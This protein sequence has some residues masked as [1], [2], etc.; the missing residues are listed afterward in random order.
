MSPPSL[1]GAAL[2]PALGG[3]QGRHWLGYIQ[4]N[5]AAFKTIDPVND[6]RLL[7]ADDFPHGKATRPHSH[8]NR[9]P[10]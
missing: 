3:L 4:G 8:N 2:R 1:R 6:K 10:A 7:R 5:Q 9:W